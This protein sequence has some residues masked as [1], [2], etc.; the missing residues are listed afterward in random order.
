MFFLSS[1]V[2]EY[3]ASLFGATY[4]MDGARLEKG[5]I[6][7][8]PVR[9]RALTILPFELYMIRRP[10]MMRSSMLWGGDDLRQAVKEFGSFNRHYIDGKLPFD[11][12]EVVGATTIDAF[13]SRLRRELAGTFTERFAPSI[14]VGHQRSRSIALHVGFGRPPDADI[15]VD[16]PLDSTFVAA[17]VLSFDRQS[18]T[19][20][21]VKSEGRSPGHR[22]RLSRMRRCSLAL[23]WRRP[24]ERGS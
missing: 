14:K 18:S 12:F 2:V 1:G 20:Q 11:M 22:N 19:G 13:V 21:V 7:V 16:M 5:D 8:L 24:F 3:F 23:S 10:S 15:L 9:S 6:G 17:S 4:L